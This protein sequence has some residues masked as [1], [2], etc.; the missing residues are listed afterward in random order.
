MSTYK[1][2][3]FIADDEASYDGVFLGS[4]WSQ[5]NNTTWLGYVLTCKYQASLVRLASDQ[6]SR[7]IDL[8]S[9]TKYKSLTTCVKAVK[10][11]YRDHAQK[12]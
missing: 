6:H 8:L 4:G 1:A 12:S 11:F 5:G 7:F 3:F 10:R 2:L 9:V